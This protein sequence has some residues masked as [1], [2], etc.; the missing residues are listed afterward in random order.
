MRHRVISQW[1]E[2]QCLADGVLLF[3][4]PYVDPLLRCNIWLVRGRR[5][6]LLI[7]TGL[8]VVSLRNALTPLLERQVIAVATHTH[9]D[10]VGSMH[11]FEHRVVHRC[12]AAALLSPRG[13]A[14]LIRGNL[15]DATVTML[16][17]AGYPL[18]TEELLTAYPVAGY[19]PSLFATL[20]ASPTR[21]VDEGDVIDLGDRAFTVLHLPGHSPGSIGLWESRSGTLFSGDA[22]YDGPLLDELAGSSIPDYLVTMAR[23][24]DLP[25]EVVHAGHDSSFNRRRLVELT[26]AYI[27]HR[28]S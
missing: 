21:V 2:S 20:P 16:R 1:Y 25:V 27:R 11:E 23:L 6:D 7:D 18:E 12:E 5:A 10:H 28:A 9:Y 8:G 19:D 14:T 17:K 3:W 22:L 26:T 24:R 4:E 15:G 13:H